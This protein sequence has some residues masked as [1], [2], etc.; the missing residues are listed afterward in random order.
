MIP[1]SGKTARTFK[2]DSLGNEGM[3]PFS[4]VFRKNQDILLNTTF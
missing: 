1:L 2:S 3:E 4:I